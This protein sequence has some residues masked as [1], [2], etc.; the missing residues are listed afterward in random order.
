[1]PMFPALRALSIVTGPV[2]GC[3]TPIL[4]LFDPFLDVRTRLPQARVPTVG[5]SGMKKSRKGGS[6]QH[7]PK[8]GTP[9]NQTWERHEGTTHLEHPFTDDPSAERGPWAMILAI[10]LVVAVVA[11]FVGWLFIT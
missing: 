7:L 2:Y 11:G 9:Q 5:S 8:V 3:P 1:M 10:I 4:C 6:R